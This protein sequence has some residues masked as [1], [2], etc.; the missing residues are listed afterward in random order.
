MNAICVAET[1]GWR[2][3]R[4]SIC[5]EDGAEMTSVHAR[6]VAIAPRWWSRICVE[7]RGVSNGDTDTAAGNL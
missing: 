5:A 2:S 6:P 4:A 7:E 1:V 3:M